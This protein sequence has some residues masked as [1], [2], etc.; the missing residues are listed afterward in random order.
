MS[1]A[2]GCSCSGRR[3]RPR[4]PPAPSGPLRGA[5]ASRRAVLKKRIFLDRRPGLWFRCLFSRDSHNPVPPRR[6]AEYGRAFIFPA[7]HVSSRDRRGSAN[8]RRTGGEGRQRLFSL[9]GRHNPLK[10][11]KTAKGNQRKSTR[12]IQDDSKEKSKN[13]ERIQIYAELRSARD[14]GAPLT[15]GFAWSGGGRVRD[16][17]PFKERMKRVN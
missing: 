9:G 8:E 4:E 6:H 3:G 14:D 15:P 12:E 7:P 17:V 1:L 11:L 10:R 13:P 2:K 16:R 5:R